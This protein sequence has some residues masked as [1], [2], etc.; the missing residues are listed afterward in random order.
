MRVIVVGAGGQG[1]VVADILIHMRATSALQPLGFVDDDPRLIGTRVLDLPVIGALE[2]LGSTPHDAIVVAVGDNARREHVSQTLTR[3]G[4]RLV[5]VVHPFSSIGG[6]VVLGDGAMVSAGA[7][8]VAGVSV[9]AGAL[10]NTRSSVDHQS[11]LGDYVHVGPGATV[12]ANAI[13]GDRALIGTG[14]TVMSGLSIGADAVVGAG[15]VVTRDVPAGAVVTGI[16]ARARP[17]R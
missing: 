8:V 5:S 11:R 14:A 10:L 7:V 15:A 4:E 17:G 6:G 9:G 2:V 12:G 13:V 16:P 3:S 1:L